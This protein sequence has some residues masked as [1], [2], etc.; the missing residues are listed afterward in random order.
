MEC[1]NAKEF[2]IESSVVCLGNFDGLHLGHKKIIDEVIRIGNLYKL[3]KVVFSFDPHPSYLV[4]KNEFKLLFS[5]DEKKYI[6]STLNLDYLVLFPF[7][8]ST[9]NLT[10][11]E[12]FVKFLVEKLSCKYI[13]VG[14]NYFFGK[15]KSGNVE[16][17]RELSEIYNV[18]LIV[19]EHYNVFENKLSSTYIRESIDNGNIEDLNKY[20]L[21]PYIV[22]GQIVTGKR[23]GRTIG[24]PT[25]NILPNKD[26]LLPKNGVYKSNVIIDG[27]EFKGLT[28]I[29]INPT[30]SGNNII[31]ETYI[32]DFNEDAYGKEG[33]V[34]LEKFIREE[35]K[36]ASIDELKSQIKK[37]LDQITL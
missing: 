17:L 9:K 10:P 28:N 11:E 19:I 29:G 36:F 24:F 5:K 35:K 15:N 26:K 16:K 34:F 14:E 30:V 25:I 31:C 6:F 27:R 20:L 4:N 3:K 37:D 18:K 13:V 33:I 8:E 1:I 32:I 7:D 22:M 12:F 23:L 2:E 21:S